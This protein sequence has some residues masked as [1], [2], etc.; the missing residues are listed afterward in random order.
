MSD[1]EVYP[2]Q[3]KV[4][5]YVAFADGM[6]SDGHGTHVS[7]I[8]AG[9]VYDLWEQAWED[10]VSH[11]NCEDEDLVR[12]CFGDCVKGMAGPECNWNPELAC[13]MSG[14]DDDYVSDD[15]IQFCLERFALLWLVWH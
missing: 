2:D 3:R 13:P 12:S 4:I 6:D 11:E 15:D 5:Q 9:E 8:A 7:G 10:Q 14:C 1:A